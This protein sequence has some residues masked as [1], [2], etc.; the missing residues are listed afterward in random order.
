MLY[1]YVTYLK[2]VCYFYLLKNIKYQFNNINM[3]YY[4]LYIN[5]IM[6]IKLILGSK[7][8]QTF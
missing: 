2:L 8:E 4:I 3:Q 7:I 6:Y 1:F 5:H